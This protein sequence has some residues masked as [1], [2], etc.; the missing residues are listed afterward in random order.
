[1]N[2]LFFFTAEFDNGTYKVSAHIP[3]VTVRWYLFPGGCCQL[4]DPPQ[5]LEL[6]QNNIITAKEAASA[7]H[8]QPEYYFSILTSHIRS[9]PDEWKSETKRLVMSNPEPS[10]EDILQT[11]SMDIESSS[12][13]SSRLW[14]FQA[15]LRYA[16]VIYAI[17]AG[18][19]STGP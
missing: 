11:I 6:V 13:I 2:D 10:L 7:E 12:S 16:I 17:K 4:F 5:F 18:H 15:L 1:M 3:S 9:L 14:S 8:A 19:R